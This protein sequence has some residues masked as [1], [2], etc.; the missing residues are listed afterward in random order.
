MTHPWVPE[1]GCPAKSWPWYQSMAAPAHPVSGC[2]PR[3]ELKRFDVKHDPL[4]LQVGDRAYIRLHKGYNLPANVN[5][6]FGAQRTG[7]FKVIEAFPSAFL[8]AAM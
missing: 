2:C 3:I 5:R 8:S 4:K 6:K 7:P 1:A